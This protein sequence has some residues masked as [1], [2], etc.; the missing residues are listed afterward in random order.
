MLKS[1]IRRRFVFSF[2]LL[3][4]L[5][6]SFLGIYL[7]QF[8]ATENMEKE[9]LNLIT[10][11]QIIEI[12]LAEQL[13]STVSATELNRKIHEISKATTLRIT[14]LDNAGTVLAD[15]SEPADTLDNHLMRP[16][17]Q[18][19]FQGPYSTAIRHSDTLHENMLYVAVPVYKNG[20]L[21]GIVRTSSSLT[22]IENSYLYIKKAI[23]LGLLIAILLATLV[24]FILANRQIRPILQMTKDALAITNGNLK[25]RLHIH[26]GDELEIL[27]RTINKLT[28]HLA[29]RIRTSEAEAHKQALILENMDNGVILIDPQGRIMTANR[30][31]RELFRLTPALLGKNSINAIGS[32][33]LSK[34]AQEVLTTNTSKSIIFPLIINQTKKTFSVFFAPFPNEKELHVLSVFHDISLLQELS[35]RQT[36]F[37]ANAAHEIATPLTSISGFAETLLDDDFSDPKQSK[38]FI[39]IIYKEA[40][41]MNRL[42]K[43]LLQ[44]AKLDSA[45]YRQ[46]IQVSLFSCKEIL[47]TVQTKLQK[48]IEDK[49]QTLQLF[50]P[51]EPA[52][53]SANKDLF[54]QLIINLT[55][56]AIKYT[57]AQGTITLS[58]QVKENKTLLFIKDNGIG[59]EATDLP[60]I[61]ERFY[62]ADKA[63]TRTGGGSGIGLSLVH[64]LV[65][66]FG[67][68]ITVESKP[69][70]GTTFLLEF[71]HITSK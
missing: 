44:L 67:G 10:N 30:Q 45:E 32:T 24:G 29:K 6:L 51:N 14:M 40:Q 65:T 37:V 69:Q 22:P 41:R 46:Q 47:M 63:R 57:P 13:S 19:A 59:I 38:A 3:S 28:S 4:V 1:K 53:I 62:R 5:L 43:D 31:A 60:F 2:V 11:A 8:F 33:V 52:V 25:R 42:T 49:Q 34:T 18:G 48:Q 50:L 16:E 58:C 54:L 26:T 7:L 15:S 35:I 61:F 27:A 64:F 17:I 21:I 9:K 12:T 70:Q 71:P 39:A 23:L 66:L 68:K 36:E 56:N 20:V 55:E